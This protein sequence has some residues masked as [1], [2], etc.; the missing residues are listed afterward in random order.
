MALLPPV[1]TYWLS[2][3]HLVTNGPGD[4]HNHVP[5]AINLVLYDTFDKLFSMFHAPGNALHA[6]MMSCLLEDHSGPDWRANSAVPDT[7]DR[8]R[9]GECLTHLHQKNTVQF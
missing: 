7:W 9:I 1:A 4:N 5:T 6:R 3:H 8:D 2:H